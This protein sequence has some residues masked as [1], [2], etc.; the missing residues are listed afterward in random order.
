MPG[1][2]MSERKTVERVMERMYRHYEKITGR[3]PDGRT[4]RAMEERVKKTAQLIQNR[5]TRR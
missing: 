2:Y 5:K 1:S 4:R 3:T